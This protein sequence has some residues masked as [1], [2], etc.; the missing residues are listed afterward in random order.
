MI[1]SKCAKESK[2]KIDYNA[3]SE[4]TVCDKCEQITICYSDDDCEIAEINL[5]LF[6]D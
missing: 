6:E 4:W 3:E 2:L 5:D 1:C